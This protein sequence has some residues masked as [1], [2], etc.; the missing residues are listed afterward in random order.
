[1]SPPPLETRANSSPRSSPLTDAVILHAAKTHRTKSKAD[2]ESFGR[3]RV[4]SSLAWGFGSLFVGQLIDQ[5][6]IDV[7]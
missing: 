2:D 6:G 3:Q 7:M 5:F 1:L 4:F